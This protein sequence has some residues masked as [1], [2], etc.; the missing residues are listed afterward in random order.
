MSDDNEDIV[1]VLAAARARTEY[2]EQDLSLALHLFH[3]TLAWTLTIARPEQAE[4]LRGQVHAKI[5]QLPQ[6][7]RIG[8][9]L[10]KLDEQSGGLLETHGIW[11]A[12]W[13]YEPRHIQTLPPV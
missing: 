9:Q 12:R 4:R 7:C 2:F 6:G 5:L 13:V 1:L 11:L 10:I 3:T 8:Q